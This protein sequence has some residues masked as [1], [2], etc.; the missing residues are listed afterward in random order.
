MNLFFRLR[1]RLLWTR[2][3]CLQNHSFLTQES[4]GAGKNWQNQSFQHSIRTR[5][6]ELQL[7]R[8]LKNKK[9]WN[10]KVQGKNQ[11]Y[12][13]SNWSEDSRTRKNEIR[14]CREKIKYTKAY[15]Q[16]CISLTEK[17]R[18]WREREAA[19][20][21]GARSNDGDGVDDGATS[22]EWECQRELN[23]SWETEIESVCKFELSFL[24]FFRK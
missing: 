4:E 6:N 8:R 17:R 14:R 13:S 22:S 23:F 2:F 21:T 15:V 10:Q 19:T 18:R 11:I 20:A 1:N 5:K 3:L 16:Y 9:K 7:I 24:D 12:E